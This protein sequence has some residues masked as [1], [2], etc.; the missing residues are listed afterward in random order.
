M[1]WSCASPKC[2]WRHIAPREDARCLRQRNP[3]ALVRALSP[4]TT[5][6]LR[7][8]PGARR[9]RSLAKAAATTVGCASC[10]SADPPTPPLSAT[11]ESDAL[12]TGWFPVTIAT[13]TTRW[14]FS[15]IVSSCSE[16]AASPP[17]D[18][19][20]PA[21]PGVA[22]ARLVGARRLT[23]TGPAGTGKTTMLRVAYEALTAQRR[24]RSSGVA[25][26]CPSAGG[27]VS[28]VVVH[29]LTG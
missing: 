11:L 25:A 18:R 13:R 3:E 24:R 16:G 9:K 17:D 19:E 7:I 10:M 15:Y 27:P 28:A 1:R 6:S 21:V 29:R 4:S 12:T 5:A 22:C 8:R 26:C 2:S 14:R 20:A 23:V